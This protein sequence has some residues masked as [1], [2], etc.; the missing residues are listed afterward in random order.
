MRIW[1]VPSQMETK[2]R[3]I[4]DEM[5]HFPP[6]LVRLAFQRFNITLFLVNAVCWGHCG[7]GG[8][9]FLR[10]NLLSPINKSPCKQSK[11]YCDRGS[12]G[13]LHGCSYKDIFTDSSWK[14]SSSFDNRVDSSPISWWLF[15]LSQGKLLLFWIPTV[16]VCVLF[17]CVYYC[18]WEHWTRLTFFA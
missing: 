7:D 17:A 8:L 18:V 5:K 9:D 3:F 2:T 4:T 13:V 10:K 15:S 14:Q 6:G 11:N 12:T 1:T 16:C